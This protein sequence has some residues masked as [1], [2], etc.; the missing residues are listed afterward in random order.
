MNNY[1]PQVTFLSHKTLIYL[2]LATFQQGKLHH[3]MHNDSNNAKF[4]PI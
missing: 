2:Q 4:Q 3:C 1:I